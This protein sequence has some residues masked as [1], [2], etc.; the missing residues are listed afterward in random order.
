LELLIQ[1]SYYKPKLNVSLSCWFLVEAGYSNSLWFFHSLG[2]HF[3]IDNASL[4]ITIQG[5]AV[6]LTW[7]WTSPASLLSSAEY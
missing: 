7:M 3:G 2:I 6:D 4:I 5:A 1:V